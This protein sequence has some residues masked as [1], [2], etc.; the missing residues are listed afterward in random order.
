MNWKTSMQNFEMGIFPPIAQTKRKF[1]Q[2]CL[3]VN[4][5]ELLVFA[6]NSPMI[7][8]KTIQLLKL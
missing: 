3:V 5:Y 4:L 6:Q 7:L 1:Y 2:V 8:S